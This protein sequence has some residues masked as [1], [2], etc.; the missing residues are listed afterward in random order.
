[1]MGEAYRGLFFSPNVFIMLLYCSGC[2]EKFTFL[3]DA[4]LL[5]MADYQQSDQFP[6]RCR[7]QAPTDRARSGQIYPDWPLSTPLPS[8][9][10]S[11]RGMWAAPVWLRLCLPCTRWSV[12]SLST[13]G[14]SC[15]VFWRYFKTKTLGAK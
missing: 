4:L 15:R 1:M 3:E 12:V 5:P 9:P 2:S 6:N 8:S 14:L 7:R 11:A 13:P 10:S